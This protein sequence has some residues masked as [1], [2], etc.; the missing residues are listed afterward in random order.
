MNKLPTASPTS[1]PA[2]L[3]LMLDRLAAQASQSGRLV[4]ALDAT[5]SRQETSDRLLT[6]G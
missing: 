2:K 5:M 1:S 3:D 4:F 6:A